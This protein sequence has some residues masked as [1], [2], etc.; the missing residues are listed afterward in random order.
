MARV[1]EGE[2]TESVYLPYGAW[3]VVSPFN[4]PLALA[5]GMVG[6]ALATGNTVVLKPSEEAPF[7]GASL[8]DALWAAGVP[9][10]ALGLL[11]GPGE[12]VGA[13]LVAHPLTRGVAFTGSYEVGMSIWRGFSDRWPKPVVVEMGGKNP[14]VVTARADLPAAAAAVVRAAFG[15]GGQKCSAC[16]RV[17]VFREVEREFVEELVSATR[18]LAVGNPLSRDGRLGPLRDGAAVGLIIIWRA[19]VRPFTPKQ[20]ALLRTFA[21]QAAL[22]LDNERLRGE[23]EGRNRELTEA[24]EW[25]S[26]TGDILRIIARSP[27]GSAVSRSPSADRR[28]S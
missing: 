8:C 23:L 13:A 18:A 25:E 19:R 7:S 22:A 21:D 1:T 24:L 6:A 3:T 26:A 9:R 14:T 4:F 27:S 2:A 20:I 11:F 28:T 10:G 15:F 16:S 12:E 5:A 17:Y